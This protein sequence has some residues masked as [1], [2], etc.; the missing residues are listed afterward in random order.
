MYVYT[1]IH[2]PMEKEREGE[3][4][5]IL[6]CENV[7]VGVKSYIWKQAGLVTWPTCKWKFPNSTCRLTAR[8]TLHHITKTDIYNMN[9][10]AM[11]C[12]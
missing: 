1:H 8:M 9:I 5:W 11:D 10:G 3:R 6:G 4:D 2:I 12:L 7:R